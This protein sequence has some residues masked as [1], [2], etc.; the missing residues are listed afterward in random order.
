M[1]AIEFNA[2]IELKEYHSFIM[3][4]SRSVYL[5]TP[6][7]V[8]RGSKLP[9]I[10]DSLGKLLHILS[11]N[12]QTTVQKAVDN[13]IGEVLPFWH[14]ARIPVCRRDHALER[15]NSFYDEYKLLKKNRGRR[16]SSQIHKEE[17][18]KEKSSNLLDLAHRDAMSLIKNHEDKAF[19][20]AQREPG[21]RGCMAGVDK[22]Q[23]KIEKNKAQRVEDEK[24]RKEI[25]MSYALDKVAELS[26]SSESSTDSSPIRGAEGGHRNVKQIS[27][28]LRPVNVLT[29]GLV[30]SLDRAKVSDRDAVY[31]LGEA[32]RA[33]GHDIGDFN[34]NRSSIRRERMARRQ[35]MASHLMK[36][37]TTDSVLVV[38]WDGKLMEDLTSK[39]Q[40][41]RL[42]ILVSAQGKTQLL[43]VAKLTSGK[44]TC[45]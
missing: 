12:P 18:F 7:E 40:V 9:S 19:L 11:S 31:V 27:E 41:D 3:S 21:R 4:K 6:L 29:G 38:H 36:E 16:S 10:G 35:E 43:N 33:F 45:N 44:G 17:Y 30:A 42:P 14:R 13:V 24:R 22:C 5:I 32:A 37:F 8:I 23:E 26:T 25:S 39:K 1:S 28:K 34:I 15:L 2:C 20:Q